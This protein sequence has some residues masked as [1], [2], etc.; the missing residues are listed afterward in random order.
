[1]PPLSHPFDVVIAGAGLAGGSLAVRLAKAGARVALVDPG[2]FPR[3]KLCG[4][5]LSPEAW[6]ALDRLGLSEAV[7]R[8]GYHAIRRIRLST[9]R[10]RVLE[11][12]FT[13]P[14]G[15]PGI[16]L[17][18][19]TLDDLLVRQARAAGVEVI[20]EARVSG[21]IVCGGR[22][23]G[24]TARRSAEGTFE[25]RAT[26]TVAAS[27]RH[28]GLV[29]RTGTTRAR[30]WRRPRLFG[31]KRHLTVADPDAA[32]PGGTVGLHL[33]PGGY[34]GTCRVEAPLTNV[35]ALLPESSLRGHRG[36]LDRLAG[37]LFG[38]N[39][40]LARLWEAGTPAS[41]WKTVAGV[42]VEASAPARRHPLRGRLP[43]D[44]RPAGGTGDDHGPARRGPGPVRR[45]G[46]GRRLGRPIAQ[47]ATTPP[48][49]AGS[50]AGSTSA[51]SSTTSW[52]TRI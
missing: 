29:S 50:T 26:V 9:P 21:P 22:V 30:S 31:L 48:G 43:G 8:S 47:R 3:E 12:D 37:D 49:I 38:G 13:G 14:D 24:V 23:A 33:L 5:F 32:E 7:E 1:M 25:V 51:A 10:G 19:S 41:P 11:G 42:R 39:P 2:R 20:E 35:C 17:S 46:P 6:G 28:S 45:P 44:D 16:G 15:R 18:R 4:E 36:D 40:R 27:G 52:S 34:V